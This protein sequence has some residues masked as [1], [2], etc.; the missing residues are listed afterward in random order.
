MPVPQ[1]KG[2]EWWTGGVTGYLS[3]WGQAQV[4]ALVVMSEKFGLELKDHQIAEHVTKVGGGHPSHACIACWRAT[5]D[6]DVDWYPGKTKEDRKR[7]GP[8]PLFN[9]QKKR[10]VA[11]SAMA[12][13]RRGIEPSYR[14]VVAHTPNAS[15]N[16]QTGQPFTQKYLMEV[17]RTMC[18]DDDPLDPWDH[19]LPYQKT[20]LS[21]ELIADRLVWLRKML[22]LGYPANW[23][24]I[25]PTHCVN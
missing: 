6:N 2:P 25:A 16:P 17:F 8:K 11:M 23:F 12:L 18:Y 24:R 19:M 14:A 15:L 5:F 10:A 7:P 21:P 22:A 4:Y 9:A 20:A 1:P 3:P 13:E